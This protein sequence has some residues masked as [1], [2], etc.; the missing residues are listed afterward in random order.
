MY[1]LS[2]VL[3][4]IFFLLISNLTYAI[5]SLGECLNSISALYQQSTLDKFSSNVI[6]ENAN[7]I[8]LPKIANT[9]KI[10]LN[11]LNDS[12]L[13]DAKKTY[14]II[15]PGNMG[16][17][18]HNTNHN[19]GYD[20]TADLIHYFQAVGV[21][22]ETQAKHHMNFSEVLTFNSKEFGDD[23]DIVDT[24]RFLSEATSEYF[25]NKD[26]E[27]FVTL[28]YKDQFNIVILRRVGFYNDGGD[29]FIPFIK[30]V[31]G[32]P[33]NIILIRDDLNG[34]LGTVSTTKNPVTEYDGNKALL[35]L[36]NNINAWSLT[37]RIT[38]KILPILTQFD[39]EH[40]FQISETA[41][42][43]FN[44]FIKELKFSLWLKVVEV[45]DRQD[46]IGFQ[47]S[48][49]NILKPMV[50]NFYSELQSEIR[51]LV[52]EQLKEI[53]DLQASI[54]HAENKKQAGD[55]MRKR[56]QELAQQDENYFFYQKFEEIIKKS[57]DKKLPMLNIIAKSFLEGF[58]PRKMQNPFSTINIGTDYLQWI[59]TSKLNGYPPLP[60]GMDASKHG[61]K[62]HFVLSQKDPEVFNQQFRNQ[63]FQA[64][65]EIIAKD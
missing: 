47:N 21:S 16:E 36:H 40:I 56:I 11:N 52:Q 41:Q 6:V 62:P 48:T 38:E 42:L 63:V 15:L 4:L 24:Q 10:I 54:R 35:S 53:A 2:K 37:S 12:L 22:K 39:K 26:G 9:L 60:Q 44:Q 61:G 18:W 57:N 59:E 65:E 29:F 31:G 19:V 45:K 49:I 20:I 32:L 28:N 58:D 23:V 51:P 13:P 30:H 64:I 33:E 34:K 17:T 8:K 3:Y 55:N 50:T 27:V 43:S 25:R 14:F 46:N 7:N 1:Q 5:N